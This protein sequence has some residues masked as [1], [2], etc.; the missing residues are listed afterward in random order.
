[1]RLPV[2]FCVV[3]VGCSLAHAQAV[4]G[5]R[6][7]NTAAACVPAS[8][9]T[10][11]LDALGCGEIAIPSP[12]FTEAERLVGGNGPHRYDL[13]QDITRSQRPRHATACCY[14]L[15]YP[16]PPPPPH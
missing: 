5:W 14:V 8:A 1:M 15:A 9:T 12:A 13:N 4:S 7:A 2:L 11:P 6:P 16:P 10:P 3:L